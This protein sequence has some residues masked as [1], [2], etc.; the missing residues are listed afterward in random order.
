MKSFPSCWNKTL[1]QLGFRRKPRKNLGGKAYGRR[2]LFE[3]LEAREMLTVAGPVNT[4]LD[5]EDQPGLYSLRDA[6]AEANSQNDPDI[7]Q[8][9][10]GLTG[11]IV[12]NGS[13]LQITKPLTIEGPGAD[14]LSI[15]GNLASRVFEITATGSATISGLTVT[16]G[17]AVNGGGIY[18]TG[19]LTLENMRILDNNADGGGGLYSNNA[20]VNVFDSTF[21]ENTAIHGGGARIGQGSSQIVISSST[22]S[23]NKAT[24]TSASNTA[25][26]LLIVGSTT[27]LQAQIRNSTFSGNESFSSGGL[28]IRNNANVNII[29]STITENIANVSDGGISVL[30]TSTVLVQNT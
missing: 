18:T 5:V 19:S 22:F 30:D 29:N 8:F 21:E 25:G 14:I 2:P 6:I 12:L 11:T 27:P 1:A 17:N 4:L 20:P 9:A 28:R 3:N 13:Q 10:T 26:G 24:N 23:N 15:S 16:R 7:I